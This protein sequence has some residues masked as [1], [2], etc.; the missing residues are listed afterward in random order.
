MLSDRKLYRLRFDKKLLCPLVWREIILSWGLTKI[1]LTCGLSKNVSKNYSVI[2]D[3]RQVLSSAAPT[4]AEGAGGSFTYFRFNSLL[5]LFLQLIIK[6]PLLH[7]LSSTL[8]FYSFQLV[9]IKD[10]TINTFA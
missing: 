5:F 8:C 7:I 4:L 6:E 3:K 9:L 2:E 1:I 10:M